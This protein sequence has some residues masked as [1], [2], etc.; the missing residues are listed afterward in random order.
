MPGGSFLKNRPNHSNSI[1]SVLNHDVARDFV[2][3]EYMT[4]QGAVMKSWK[5]RYFSLNPQNNHIA[6]YKSAADC[7][8][9]KKP[10]GLIPLEDARARRKDDPKRKH[11]MEIYYPKFP[12]KRIYKILAKS[13]HAV[14]CWVDTINQ[15]TI[16]D[17]TS[18]SLSSFI[19]PP[20]HSEMHLEENG[21]PSPRS[22]SSPP[23]SLS[24]TSSPPSDGLFT[25]Q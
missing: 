1:T 12:K 22:T 19:L 3:H 11:M 21:S 25:S 7:L 20:S 17:R 8:E 6:Y 4:K 10:L 14:N 5:R 18:V 16:Q 13:E 2:R 9:K 15:L 23:P 24:P